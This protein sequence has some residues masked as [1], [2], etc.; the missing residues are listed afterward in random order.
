[1][2]SEPNYSLYS[3]C[4]VVVVVVVDIVFVVLVFVPIHIRLSYGQ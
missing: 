2:R 3:G 1:M 4:F